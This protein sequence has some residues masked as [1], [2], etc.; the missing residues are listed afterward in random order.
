MTLQYTPTLLHNYE[1]YY[2]S[3]RLHEFPVILLVG[4]LEQSI[5]QIIPLSSLAYIQLTNLMKD[6]IETVIPDTLNMV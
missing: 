4:V 1:Y 2:Y 6:A 3:F 5:G